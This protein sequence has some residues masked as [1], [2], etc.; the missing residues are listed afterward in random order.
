MNQDARDGS[1]KL[2]LHF[3]VAKLSVAVRGTEAI[4]FAVQGSNADGWTLDPLLHIRGGGTD[5]ATRADAVRCFR[6]I[7]TPCVAAGECRA[8]SLGPQQGKLQYCLVLV[9]RDEE[10]HVRAAVGIITYAADRADA[11]RKLRVLQEFKEQGGC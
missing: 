11:V 3:L 10:R 4:T 9:L 1:V 8:V 5:D 2:F 7:I 6:D